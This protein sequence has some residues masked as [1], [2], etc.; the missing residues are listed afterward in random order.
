[1]GT[2]ETTKMRIEACV[3][4]G[5]MMR[6]IFVGAPFALGCYTH[7][8]GHSP[9]VNLL[10]W[11][12]GTFFLLAYLVGLFCF[13]RASWKMVAG[14]RLSFWRGLERDFIQLGLVYGL[15]CVLSAYFVGALAGDL[16]YYAHWAT[17]SPWRRLVVRRS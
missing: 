13:L 11:G 12:F 4:G 3:L 10:G 5:M 6:M 8:D 9:F 7:G 16:Y 2:L 17:L 14:G 15:G 1:M